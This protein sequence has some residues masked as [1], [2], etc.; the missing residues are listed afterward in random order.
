MSP[1]TVKYFLFT[2]LLYNLF[3]RSTIFEQHG[4][5]SWSHYLRTIVLLEYGRI[6][7][8]LHPLSLYGFFPF[9]YASGISLLLGS[10]QLTTN[11]PIYQIIIYSSIFFA[12]IFNL[13]LFILCR[14]FKFNS[15]IILLALL[16]SSSTIT[17]LTYTTSVAS[18]RGALISLTPITAFLLFRSV[19]YNGF[20]LRYLVLFLITLNGLF[21]LHLMFGH[22]ILMI[23]MPHIFWLFYKR[24]TFFSFHSFKNK[25][26]IYS[27]V[28]LFLI[29]IFIQYLGI[30]WAKVGVSDYYPIINNTNFLFGMINI[31][32]SYLHV[33]GSSLIFL[34]FGVIFLL[35]SKGKFNRNFLLF[36]I[37]LSSVF[38]FDT[39]YFLAFFTFIFA[40]VA[41]Y[42]C[43]IAIQSDKNIL[44][45]LLYI[46]AYL[47]FIYHFYS[48]S[49]IIITSIGLLGIGILL[50]SLINENRIIHNSKM[51]II[52]ILISLYPINQVVIEGYDQINDYPNSG[53][54]A[55]SSHHFNRAF[56]VDKYVSGKIFAN[57]PIIANPMCALSENI[58][59]ATYYDII[60]YPALIGLLEVDT[61]ITHLKNYYDASIFE[62]NL[63]D[64]HNINLGIELISRGD[65]DLASK[66]EVEVVV[67]RN[68]NYLSDNPGEEMEDLETTFN[69][70]LFSERYVIYSDSG[71]EFYYYNS[72]E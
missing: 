27:Y 3:L 37:F 13:S 12:L 14:Y 45:I 62:N 6:T 4:G 31:G 39:Q 24:Q 52:I 65:I 71:S 61:N 66:H 57:T 32:A 8:Y 2:I 30:T 49:Q 69:K 46:T 17:Y 29:I 19:G 20:N 33:Y 9:S 40:I 1:R 28:L 18:P 63:G 35:N 54:Y 55:I 26:F 48:D 70:Y 5:D 53:D 59:A 16:F 42:G 41:A 58:R 21:S 51:F 15:Q 67:I 56:W 43:Y 36:P 10:L 25:Y 11:I 22:F 60:E 64:R 47:P 7:W 23:M 44:V 38:I 68:E 72:Y 50:V 34:P